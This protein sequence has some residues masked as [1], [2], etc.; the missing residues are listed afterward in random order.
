[1]PILSITIYR[2]DGKLSTSAFDTAGAL[3]GYKAEHVKGP[4]DEGA[5]GPLNS[6]LTIRKGDD[7]AMIDL[8]QVPEGRAKGLALA[9]VIARRL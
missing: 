6:T 8:R 3:M 7:G 4:W 1:V 9:R 2:G 5:F